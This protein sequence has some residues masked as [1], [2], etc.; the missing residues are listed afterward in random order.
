MQFTLIVEEFGV[1]YV[2]KEHALHLKQTIGDNYT[3]TLE[4]YVRQY[5]GITIY[6]DYRRRQVHLLMPNYVTKALKQFDH[7]IQKP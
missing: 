4:W 1:K 7:K 6:W 5:I 2:G 3:V